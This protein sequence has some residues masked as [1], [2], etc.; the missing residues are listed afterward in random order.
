MNL[1]DAGQ[2]LA[3][4]IGVMLG[5]HGAMQVQIDRI[6][7]PGV[8]Q[9]LQDFGGDRLERIAC[10]RGRGDRPR[11]QDRH[12]LPTGLVGKV[13]GA[14]HAQVHPPDRIAQGRASGHR[15]IAAALLKRGH[16]GGRAGEAVTFVQEPGE[17][18]FHGQSRT[19]AS[20]CNISIDKQYK[21]IE[22]DSCE[23][24]LC[25]QNFP[26]IRKETI[27][28]RELNGVPVFDAH[29]ADK[30]S[31]DALFVRAAARAVAVMSVFE[32]AHKPLTLNEIAEL[33]G[34]DRSAAQ[35]MIHTLQE[36]GMIVRD[37]QDRGYLPGRRVLTMACSHLRLNPVLR[38]AAQFCWS[39]GGARANGWICRC[40]TTRG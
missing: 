31:N 14:R 24:T 1:A 17:G 25:R 8:A 7:R 21:Y 16:I 12:H 37:E 9:A 36:L 23:V 38:H 10:H 34:L 13:E 11:P 29:E 20:E 19:F 28:F 6:Q 22:D 27:L 2:K 32:F 18:D 26:W 39:C 33:A 3:F 15:D 35:R 40:G 5:H 30:F 4:A